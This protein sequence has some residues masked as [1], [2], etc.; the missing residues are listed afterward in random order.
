MTS[1]PHPTSGGVDARAA[2]PF[3]PRTA[4]LGLGAFGAFGL[5][6]SVLYARTGLGLPCPLRA[7]TG[8][9][10]PLCGGTRLG[11]ALLHGDVAAA[12]AANPLVLVGLVVLTALGVTWLVEA[13]GGPAVRPPAPVA[14]LVRRVSP[15]GWTAI[16]LGAAVVY[17]VARNLWFPL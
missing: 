13:L 7:L 2:R 1:R 10:C 11:G 4:V 9:D 12:F 14:A 3:D 8:W 5:G 17:A 6:L 16:L 15:A